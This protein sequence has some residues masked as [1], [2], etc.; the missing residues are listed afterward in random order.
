MI[1]AANAIRIDDRTALSYFKNNARKE[2]FPISEEG[3]SSFAVKIRQPIGSTILLSPALQDPKENISQK[4]MEEYLTM[5]NRLR[6]R[7]YLSPGHAYYC[8]KT[9]KNTGTEA[10]EP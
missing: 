6:T 1:D 10:A 9:Q 3:E 2:G 8:F 4:H 5:T 7:S